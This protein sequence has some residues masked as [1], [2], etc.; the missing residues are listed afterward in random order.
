[1]AAEAESRLAAQ[2]VF[3]V[4][5]V[6]AALAEGC[7][8]QAPYD[9]ILIEGAVEEVPQALIDQLREGGRIVALFRE[10]NLGT[11]R[12]G[13]KLDGR[14]NWRFAFNAA[15]PVLPGFARQRGFVL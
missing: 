15:A 13:H 12:L 3:S 14:V 4:A 7:P 6:K 11:V 10:D 5:V 9:A 1:M 8:G 2:D